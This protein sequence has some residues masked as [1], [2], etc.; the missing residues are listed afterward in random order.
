VLVNFSALAI[1]VAPVA[2]QT[3]LTVPPIGRDAAQ[4]MTRRKRSVVDFQAVSI[5]GSDLVAAQ[6]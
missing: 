6:P 5:C 3:V 2:A 4:D 1:F